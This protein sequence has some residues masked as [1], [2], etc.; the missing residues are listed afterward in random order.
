MNKKAI[1]LLLLTYV[2]LFG[3]SQELEYWLP[4]KRLEKLSI[5]KIDKCDSVYNYPFRKVVF[6]S[7]NRVALFGFKGADPSLCKIIPLKQMGSWKVKDTIFHTLPPNIAMGSKV[8]LKVWNDTLYVTLSKND[9][10]F[11]QK[12]IRGYRNIHFTD[13]KE[14]EVGN[15]LLSGRY[16]LNKGDTAIQFE[17][18][19]IIRAY[20]KNI[21]TNWNYNFYGF[22]HYAPGSCR[23]VDSLAIGIVEFSGNG[24][25]HNY[26]IKGTNKGIDFYEITKA[27]SLWWNESLI[28]FSFSLFLLPEP[29]VVTK[30]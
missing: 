17:D 24:L 11:T 21:R 19:G 10:F 13:N 8:A 30:D 28:E 5:S 7:A 27:S 3:Q 26:F 23:G 22:K 4:Q 25:R 16:L 29:S 18:N 20:S 15:I 2:H 1:L 9:V 12:F 14:T 6:I